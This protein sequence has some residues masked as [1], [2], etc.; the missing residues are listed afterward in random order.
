MIKILEKVISP[1]HQLDFMCMKFLNY[2][3]D[4]LINSKIM[5][6]YIYLII[7]EMISRDNGFIG[8]RT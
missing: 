1:L 8:N 7:R 5:K 6:R 2:Y 4:N 3:E